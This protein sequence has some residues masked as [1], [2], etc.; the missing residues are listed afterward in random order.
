MIKQLF[1]TAALLVPGL[2]YAA[3]PGANLSV[4]VIPAGPNNP[5]TPPTQA[6]VANFN[7]CVVCI[8]FTAPTGGVFVNGA[9]VAGAN[10]SN[11][12]TWLDC[13][14]ASNPI[15]F[16]GSN[17]L[18]TGALPCPDVVSDGLGNPRVL[19]QWNGPLTSAN[20]NGMKLYNNGNGTGIMAPTNNYMEATFMVPQFPRFGYIEGHWLG[21]AGEIPSNVHNQL[22]FDAFEVN[23]DLNAGA[24]ASSM[25][26]WHAGNQTL[27]VNWFGTFPPQ[28]GGYNL[29]TQYL[30]IGQ[31]MTNDGTTL[32]KCMW[33]N[34][35]F[36]N[37]VSHSVDGG[38]LL[39]W[40][41]GD[42]KSRMQTYF[43][44]TGCLQCSTGTTTDM[45]AY[46]KSFYLWSCSDWQTIACRTN[47]ADPGGY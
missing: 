10:G 32:Y 26:S 47:S 43:I 38:A 2:A 30:K 34:D 20:V 3:N 33:I 25:G 13:A 37:C 27:G 18:N 8:D 9:Q 45:L 11:P 19:R 41:L 35:V 21:G 24:Y 42:A 15:W 36:Q 1:F 14:G 31:R 17:G 7:T 39:D 46:A 28:Y 22:E 16:H 29:S 4:Q 12:A 40:E 23:T 6:T 5:P 44:L